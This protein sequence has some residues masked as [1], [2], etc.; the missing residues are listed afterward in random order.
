MTYKVIEIY[1]LITLFRYEHN[2]CSCFE[3]RCHDQNHAGTY[4]WVSL[5][6][7]NVRLGAYT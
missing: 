2:D 5:L 6:K 4:T 7:I 3:S 1:G